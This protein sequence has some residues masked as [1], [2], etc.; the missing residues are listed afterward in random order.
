[1]N[2]DK[3]FRDLPNLP[4]Q[5]P[6]GHNAPFIAA[7]H[8][9]VRVRTPSRGSYQGLKLCFLTQSVHCAVD[10]VKGAVDFAGVCYVL[11]CLHF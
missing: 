10:F 2:R 9:S 4:G 7:V 3:N 8:E 6:L 5:T 11:L 1:M